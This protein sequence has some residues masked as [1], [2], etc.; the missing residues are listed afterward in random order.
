M[1]DRFVVKLSLDADGRFFLESD[2]PDSGTGILAGAARIIARRL[3]LGSV[4]ASVFSRATVQDP[5]G[6]RLQH[7]RA[8]PFWRRWLFKALE[9]LQ[10]LQ[11]SKAMSLVVRMAPAAEASMFRVFARPINGVNRLLNW[12]KSRLFPY[13]IDSFVPR[14]SGSRGMLMVGRAA[15]DAAARL[16]ASAIELAAPLLNA[17]PEELECGAPGVR[18]R[19]RPD[20]CIPWTKIAEAAG[21]SLVA[22]GQA[23]IPFGLLLDPA[24][25]NQMGPIDYMFASHGVDLAVNRSTGQVKILRYVACQ[26]VGKALNLA[27]VRGQIIGSVAMGL[28]QALLE[29]M[30]VSGGEVKN[31]TMLDYHVPTALDVPEDPIVIILESGGGHGPS[32]AKG[33]GEAGAVAAPIA[34]ANALYDALGV[35]LT[36]IPATPEDIVQ[37]ALVGSSRQ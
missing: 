37:A 1:I 9:R 26:D 7:G 6:H 17:S 2:V 36:A 30:V 3:G 12:I 10:G 32:G 8:A 15:M 11:A 4:P 20:E 18:R 28:G 19:S 35:Q 24:T 16:E 13:A 27:V 14:T 5:S 23:S 34:I 31:A 33:V 25:G 29:K 21:G 22:L